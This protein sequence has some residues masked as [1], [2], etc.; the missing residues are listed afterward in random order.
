[1]K[2]SCQEH[3]IP[4]DDLVEKW[5]FIPEAGVDGIELLGHGGFG[6]RTRLEELQ[7]ARRQGAVLS[8]ACVIMDHFIGDFDADKRRD[9]IENVK[10][11]LSVVASL[12]GEGVVTP[13]AYAL[14]SRRLPPYDPPRSDEDTRDILVGALSEL[15]EHAR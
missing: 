9:A 8:T 7:A 10:S 1:V 12:G 3:L 6:L 5:R 14:F 15:G 11:Q 13:A 2:L 4:G